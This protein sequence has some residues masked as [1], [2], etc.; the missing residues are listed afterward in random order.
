MLPRIVV[1]GA[2][3]T[4]TTTLTKA[5]AEQYDTLWVPEF[6]RVLAENAT[7]NGLEDQ[8]SYWDDQMFWLTSRAQDAMEERYAQAADGALFCD[9]D[10]FATAV[11]YDY[12]KRKGTVSGDASWGLLSAGQAQAKKHKLYILTWNDI[13]FEQDERGTRTGEKLRN[14]H[15]KRFVEYLCNSNLPFIIVQGTHE[16]RMTKALKYVGRVLAGER[17]NLTTEEIA[18]V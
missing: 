6:G 18:G 13:P 17:L 9:T 2:E 14:W 8:D 1:L 3:S 4:G 15:T 16:Q 10:S 12:Y 11:W 5:L 7:D